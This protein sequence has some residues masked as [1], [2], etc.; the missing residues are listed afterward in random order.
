MALVDPKGHFSAFMYPYAY[1][2]VS[3][4]AGNFTMEGFGQSKE[5]H[6]LHATDSIEW[7]GLAGLAQRLNLNMETFSAKF[8][9]QVSFSR[10]Y[11]EFINPDPNHNPEHNLTLTPWCRLGLVWGC[12]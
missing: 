12:T 6:V 9:D 11:S 2:K 1:S 10:S 7:I 3:K 8:L 5:G 4:S